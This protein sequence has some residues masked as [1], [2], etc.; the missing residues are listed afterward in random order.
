MKSKEPTTHP[1]ASEPQTQTLTTKEFMA[2]WKQISHMDDLS[3]TSPEWE[4]FRGLVFQDGKEIMDPSGNTCFMYAIW[5][6]KIGAAEGLFNLGC[7]PT[8][9]N[10]KGLCVV[11]SL[12]RDF[13]A[14][15]SHR[16]LEYINKV[17][18]KFPM[19]WELIDPEKKNFEVYAIRHAVEWSERFLRQDFQYPEKVKDEALVNIID[20]IAEPMDYSQIKRFEEEFRKKSGDIPSW[21]IN[22]SV[23]KAEVARRASE[24]LTEAVPELLREEVKNP[25][26]IR[27]HF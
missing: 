16:N 26:K 24:A 21:V 4:K 6:G 1:A 10:E 14:Y 13:D 12:I 23:W 8:R 3:P 20:F 18:E 11:Q 22:S 7:D 17:L 25:S 5:S 15:K 19:T 27:P 9:T 2:V